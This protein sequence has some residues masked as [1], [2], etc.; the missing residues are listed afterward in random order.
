MENARHI[1]VM[2][3]E[4]CALANATSAKKIVDATFGGGGYASAFLKLQMRPNV[5]AL[6]RDKLALRYAIRLQALAPDRFH[7]E[8]ARFGQMGTLRCMKYRP[9]DMVVFDTGLCTDQVWLQYI[10]FANARDS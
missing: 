6:D 1:P 3:Q 8:H 5:F 4:V 7:F 2:L 9:F 10:F